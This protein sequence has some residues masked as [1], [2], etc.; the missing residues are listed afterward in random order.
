[1]YAVAIKY[2]QGLDGRIHLRRLLLLNGFSL[3]LAQ[4]MGAVIVSRCFLLV[5]PPI[6]D[7]DLL[8][9]L[10]DSTSILS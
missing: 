10:L 7:D 8:L 9:H 5:A 2:Y 6:L 1:M 4:G 3:F